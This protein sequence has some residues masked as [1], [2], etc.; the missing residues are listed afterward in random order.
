VQVQEENKV[1]KPLPRSRLASLF[2]GIRMVLLLVTVVAMA[3]SLYIGASAIIW[4]F[5]LPLVVIIEVGVAF[6]QAITK[7]RRATDKLSK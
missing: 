7:K 3:L 2:Q 5:T 1:V 6:Y 4:L